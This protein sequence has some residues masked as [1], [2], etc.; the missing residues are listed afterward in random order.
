MAAIGHAPPRRHALPRPHP[1]I[2]AGRIVHCLIVLLA[3]AALAGLGQLQVFQSSQTAA[4]GYRVRALESESAQL[5]AHVRTL[6]AEIAEMTRIE[7][8]E[9]AA[10]ERLGMV[11]PS[12]TIQ[13]A[14][15]VAA[16]NTL[17]LPERY[18]APREVPPAVD[19]SWWERLLESLA[20]LR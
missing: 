2:R 11:P 17:S 18:V 8:V 6:E 12:A 9:A 1:H 20:G 7:D 3:L 14:V 16:P 4:T 10:K 19:V 13:V 5:S 15:G